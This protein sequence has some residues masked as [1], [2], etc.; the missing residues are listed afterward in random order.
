M[1]G[2][3]GI[4]DR[5]TVGRPGL[6]LLSSCAASMP[7]SGRETLC[8]KCEE[9]R[10]PKRKIYMHFMRTNGWY[11]QFLEEDLKT[12]LPLKLTLDDPEK[13]QELA[14]R[15]GASMI[16]ED[17]QAIDHGIEIGR[18]SVWLNLTQEQYQKLLKRKR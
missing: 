3:A 17:K 15:G 10:K 14:K 6:L 4:N 5:S 18:G 13:I 2:R 1:G 12:P 16:L 9:E 8:A 7:W 11:C